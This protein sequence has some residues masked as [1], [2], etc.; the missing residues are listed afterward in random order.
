MAGVKISALPALGSPQLTDIYPTVQGGVTYKVTLAQISEQISSNPTVQLATTTAL[1]ATYNNGTAGVGAT[2]INAG[3]LAALSI[4]S[5]SVVA[6]DR[7][8]VK[9]Q[10]STFQNGIYIVTTVGDGVTAWVLTRSG[11]YDEPSDIDQGDFFTI[12]AGSVNGKTQ[13]IQTAVVT[14]I[15][16]DPITFESNVVAGSGITKSNNT[17]SSSGGGMATV[18]ATGATQVISVNTRYIANRGGGV[19]FSLPATSA[20]G[21]IFSIVG[22]LGIW[23]ITQGAGQQINVGS[24]SNTLGAAGTVTAANAGDSIKLC[25]ITANTIWQVEGAPQS[26]GLV[27]A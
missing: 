17:I 11:D 5:V 12:G 8:L 4:D 24:V 26:A 19:A 22:K 6:G 7:I 25:C 9:D 14:T 3:A 13:W 23:S 18:E 2:L 1:T 20:V 21:D 10:A 15:G 16:T 27:L